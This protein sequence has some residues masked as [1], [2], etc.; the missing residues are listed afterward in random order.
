MSYAT[1]AETAN[2][3]SC[4]EITDKGDCSLFGVSIIQLLADPQKYDGKKIRVSG[5]VH[6]EDENT[7]IYLHKEDLTHHLYANGLWIIFLE[8]TFNPECRDQY[9][10]VEGIF[11]AKN[12][13]H[14]GLW[15]G[16]INITKCTALPDSP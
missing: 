5:Y 8:N 4:E 11:D 3:I 16:A 6:I 14:L 2:N 12:T 10:V 1:S 7:G 13:G 15:N 9:A